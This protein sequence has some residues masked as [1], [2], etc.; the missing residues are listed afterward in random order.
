MS[1]GFASSGIVTVISPVSSSTLT[2]SGAFSP[3]VNVVPS[4]AV[5]GLPSLSL[6]SGASTVTSSPGLPL[7]SSYPGS[8]SSFCFGV[9]SAANES[10]AIMF[11]LTTNCT[12]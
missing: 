8:Y 2:P 12:V 6:N 1:P 10:A 7:P 11:P 9:G 3:G 5:V 4:G